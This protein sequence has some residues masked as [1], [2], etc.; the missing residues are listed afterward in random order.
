LVLR[1]DLEE[2]YLERLR[3]EF[4]EADVTVVT[5]PEELRGALGEADAIIGGSP[6]SPEELAAAKRLRW[7]QVT[8]AGV[9]A[10]LTPELREHQLVLTNFSGIAAPNIADHVLAL[11]LAFAR[12]LKPLLERQARHEWG[13]D[14][15]APSTF[16]PAG[17]TLGIVGLGDIGEALAEKAHGLGMRVIAVQRHPHEPPPGVERILPSEGLAELLEES[18]HVVLSLP[19]TDA[20]EHILGADELRR[21][22]RSAY[23]FNIGRG[24]LIDQEALIAALREGRIAGAGLDVTE[25]EPLPPDSALWDLPNVIITG[26]TAASTP[27]HWERGIELLV[28]NV[29]RFLAGEELR[30]TVDTKAGY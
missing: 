21:M 13:E 2:Q 9:E 5:A 14:E 18:D 25:P 10:W 26:H 12:G 29:R 4:P 20:T 15:A 17:Q 27:R 1:V 16:E 22:R 3:R 6:L 23:L 8:S 7:V 24:G 11:L 30:N 19:L 28:D